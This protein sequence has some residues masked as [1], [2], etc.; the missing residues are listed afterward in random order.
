ALAIVLALVG[1]AGIALRRFGLP[2]ITG[3]AGRRL[4]VVETQMLGKNHRLFIVRC[5]GM[6]HLL[7]TAP[8]GASVIA[9]APAKLA[10]PQS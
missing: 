1:V 8:Q 6:E 10:G 2:G 7:V 9:T 3:G 4:S 5:D